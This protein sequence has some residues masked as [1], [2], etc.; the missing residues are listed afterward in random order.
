MSGDPKTFFASILQRSRQMKIIIGLTCLVVTLSL[1]SEEP[2]FVET[3]AL[4]TKMDRGYSMCVTNPSD[5][6][7]L[8][9]KEEKFHG[10]V[11]KRIAEMIQINEFPGIP[12]ECVT[13]RK[14]SHLYQSL[15]ATSAFNRNGRINEKVIIS[16][17]SNDEATYRSWVDYV[18]LR[19]SY[20]TTCALAIQE[21]LPEEKD[22]E[23]I[24]NQIRSL[25]EFA[26][27]LLCD[28]FNA[29]PQ[30]NVLE[31]INQFFKVFEAGPESVFNLVAKRKLTS[32]QLESIQENW[33]R[34]L[35][36][37][38]EQKD[39]STQ[40]ILMDIPKEGDQS[41]SRIDAIRLKNRI[42]METG[43]YLSA[44]VRT[45]KEEYIEVLPPSFTMPAK[46]AL[47]LEY[48]QQLFTTL[49]VAF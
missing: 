39:E 40:K 3:S 5:I 26:G 35:D 16:M 21:I 4:M 19:F 32:E 20:E 43:K 37:N 24:L 9:E 12:K 23:E 45:L 6:E 13:D 29:L 7:S 14:L 28:Y 46:P 1:Y 11:K 22:R 47:L 18:A 8:K 41:T 17:D 34:T 42:K 33:K 44:M 31:N 15:L 2:R 25:K 48:E 27:R 36:E 30:E 38:R 49:D 10:D